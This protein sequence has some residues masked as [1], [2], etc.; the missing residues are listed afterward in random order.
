[1][2]TCFVPNG[3]SF[4][5]IDYD[6]MIDDIPFHQLCCSCGAHGTLIKH[7]YYTRHLKLEN[8]TC[9]CVFFVSNVNPV[10]EHMPFWLPAVFLTHSCHYPVRFRS[11]N[12]IHLSS[13]LLHSSPGRTLISQN[14]TFIMFLRSIK[15]SGISDCYLF[16]STYVMISHSS[17]PVFPS[18]SFSLCKFVAPL[19]FFFQNPHSFPY[20]LISIDL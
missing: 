7:A 14:A 6:K 10:A 8:H 5:Q 17:L 1:M 2:I 12:I 4:S 18:V 16:L 15:H 3:K 9:S 13:L 19:I 20:H 11:Y